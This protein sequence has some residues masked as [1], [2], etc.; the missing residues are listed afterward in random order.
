MFHKE[1][2]L[3]LRWRERGRERDDEE[4]INERV[5]EWGILMS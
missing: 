3:A 4:T 5:Q 1:V 2:L